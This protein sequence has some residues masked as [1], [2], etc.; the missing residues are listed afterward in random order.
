[1]LRGT[2][3][4]VKMSTGLMSELSNISYSNEDQSSY[5]PSTNRSRKE[6]HDDENKE[7][8]KIIQKPQRDPNP[9]F[10][11]GNISEENSFVHH[12]SDENTEKTVVNNTQANLSTCEKSNVSTNGSRSLELSCNNS[13][14][15]RSLNN[16]SMKVLGNSDGLEQPNVT[17]RAKKRSVSN[18][19]V[20]N[21]SSTNKLNNTAVLEP[22][23]VTSRSKARAVSLIEL[24]N[25]TRLSK[26]DL[27]STDILDKSNAT[28]SI[29]SVVVNLGERLSIEQ[30]KK[31]KSGIKEIDLTVLSDII[32]SSP[33]NDDDNTDTN[34]TKR[35]PERLG[36]SKEIGSITST[37]K[38]C[39]R[40]RDSNVK[41][42]PAESPIPLPKRKKIK[43][44]EDTDR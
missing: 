7:N 37:P 38:E 24:K 6:V 21:R 32:V 29:G 33:T 31:K 20:R 44:L 26:N 30:L 40:T 35:K 39:L 27:N 16:S 8:K 2:N 43:V 17:V 22:C 36:I 23:N 28:K 9:N 34:L 14:V 11:L 3:E 4:W 19:D 5:T 18:S 12:N 10:D 42:E 15:L 13:S 25:Q 1:M 41:E